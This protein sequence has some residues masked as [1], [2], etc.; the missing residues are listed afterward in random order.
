VPLKGGLLPAAK[1]VNRFTESLYQDAAT[2]QRKWDALTLLAEQGGAGVAFSPAQAREA[3]LKF[4]PILGLATDTLMRGWL[5]LTAAE[6]GLG[7]SP[8]EARSCILRSPNVLLY[9]HAAVV[10]RVELLKGL[11]Y[12]QAF[13]MVL[14]ALRVLNY[15]EECV[16]EHAAWWKQ[17]G[18]DHVK[19]LTANPNRLGAPTT[20]VLQSNLDFLRRVVGMST[21]ELNNAN[22]LFGLS[23]DRRLQARYFYALREGQLARFGTINTMMQVKDSTF[24]AMVQ[25]RPQN[26]KE[27]ASE[28]EVKRYKKQVA[29]AEFVAWRERQEAQLLRAAQP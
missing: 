27:L 22:S 28:L 21:A 5:M 9:N 20:A 24:L 29:S 3:V 13:E 7:L 26:T 14:K 25:G 23:L 16:R 10:R 6:G 19:I 11:G 18:L 15:K 12:P 8:E 4:P 17:T 2:L 1:V